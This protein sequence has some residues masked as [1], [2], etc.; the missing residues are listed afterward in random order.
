MLPWLAQH[1]LR[2][3]TPQRKPRKSNWKWSDYESMERLLDQ[4][5]VK[6][7]AIRIHESTLDLRVSDL[8]TS[9]LQWNKKRIEEILP[10]FSLQIQLLK[11]SSIGAEDSYVWQP[12]QSGVYS[13]KS[14]Y[15]VKASSLIPLL[16]GN[17]NAPNQNL[18]FKWI[19]DIWSGKFSPKLRVFLWSIIQNALSLGEN[20]QRRGVTTDVVCPRCKATETT[21]HTF[22]LCPFTKEVWR[23]I[24]L[25]EPVHLAEETN[26]KHAV[27]LAMSFKCLPPT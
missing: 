12:L 13:T 24:P 18:D 27:V 11:P 10:D 16:L 2:L 9:D 5:G 20:L 23:Q 6:R 17:N 4:S 7:E 22:F 25:S 1:P 14:G 21:M 3:R 15:N 8:L 26:F 19:K